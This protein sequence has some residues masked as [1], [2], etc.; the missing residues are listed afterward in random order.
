MSPFVCDAFASVLRSAREDF[1]AR[2][3]LAGY[4]YPNL[5]PDDFTSFLV[6]TA[7]PLIGLFHAQ[8]PNETTALAQV[9]Y[10]IGLQLAGQKLI[11]RESRTPQL[12]IGWR[13]ILPQNLSLLSTAPDRMLTALSN[14]LLTP[15]L[16]AEQ[17]IDIMAGLVDQCEDIDTFLKLGQLSAWISGLAHFRP[18][19]LTAAD[20]LPPS[21]ALSALSA[22]PDWDWPGLRQGL[23]ENPWL[24]PSLAPGMP[25]AP[26][27]TRVG[28]FIGF[29]GLFST[30]PTVSCLGDDFQ[31][32]SGKGSWLLTADRFGA[33][34]HR[35]GEKE[36]QNA[37]QPPHS[38]KIA[39]RGSLLEINGKPFDISEFTPLTSEA[40]NQTT[41]ALTSAI[42]HQIAL[43]S[44]V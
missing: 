17:W 43:I 27:I 24:D 15:M 37:V 19:A 38:H 41:L 31:V 16:R 30:P 29:G 5:S 25:P 21:L 36:S 2:F 20:E 26:F 42:S 22:H 6:E 33:T 14:A 3:T 9:L 18:G 28:A 40:V 12:E 1:N 23:L 39:P 10:D 7:D 4:R 34:F 35:L 44:L 8:S 11:G 32:V 13:R